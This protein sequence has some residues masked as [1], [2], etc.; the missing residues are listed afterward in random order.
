[1]KIYVKKPIQQLI[2]LENKVKIDNTYFDDMFE[3][4]ESQR[5]IPKETLF[6]T[7]KFMIK[8]TNELDPELIKFV[9]S[10]II[11]PSTEPIN[12]TKKNQKDF[13]QIGQSKFIDTQLGSRK[14]GFF[15]E[16]GGFDGEA[17]S[18]SLF[19]ELERGWNGILIEPIPGNFKV[20]KSKNRKVYS[21]NACIGN[22]KPSIAK[23]LVSNV[24]SGRVKSMSDNHANRIDK[25]NNFKKREY[26]Y[27]PCFSLVT[28]LKAIDVK[29]VDYFS[30]DVEGG[31]NDV[32]NTIKFDKIDIE[33]FT[34]EHNG[35]E[36]ERQK[37]IKTLTANNYKELKSD[38]QDIYFKKTLENWKILLLIDY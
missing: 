37:M 11:P 2:N 6:Q 18:N 8:E 15:I 17:H 27:I 38:G 35:N 21:I 14:G 23:F 33:T 32:L 24:L 5:Y 31:E 29:K 10:L 13:S 3:A 25:E 12:L 1:M 20:L 4:T 7:M 26:L 16:A 9:K 28:I 22:G 34:I 36:V 19:F 30:L